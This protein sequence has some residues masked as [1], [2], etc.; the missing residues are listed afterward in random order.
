[1]TRLLM[2]PSMPSMALAASASAPARSASLPD[3][4]L[5]STVIFL[6]T[7]PIDS[8]TASREVTRRYQPSRSAVYVLIAP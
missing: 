8:M 4:C 3:R 5:C 1:M 6:R 2:N 7:A